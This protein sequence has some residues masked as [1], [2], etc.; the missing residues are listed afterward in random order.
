V[1]PGTVFGLLGANGAG[2]STLAKVIAGSLLPTS[3]RV[4]LGGNDA[5]TRATF[6]RARNGLLVAPEGRGIFATLSLEENLRVLLPAQADRAA[7]YDRFP[8]LA[9]RRTVAAG[10]LSGGEQQLL[11]LAPLLIDQ[12]GVLVADEPSLGLA[13]LV[14]QQVFDIL[15][16]LRD[17]GVSIILIEEKTRDVLAIAD[18]LAMLRIGEIVWRG[19]PSDTSPDQLAAAYLGMEMTETVEPPTLAKRS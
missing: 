14:T 2:K 5:T 16:E 1:A 11:S 15:R 8:G 10:L 6:W 9:R 7:V 18:E 13:P 12:P 19:R 17:E 3:G 4:F